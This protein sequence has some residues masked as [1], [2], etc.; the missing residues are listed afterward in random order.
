MP[1]YDDCKRSGVNRS[2]KST[3]RSDATTKQSNS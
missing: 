1:P 3:L 2:S